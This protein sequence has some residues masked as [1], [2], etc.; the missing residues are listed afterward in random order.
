M[1]NTKN[2][3]LFESGSFPG[4]NSWGNYFAQNEKLPLPMLDRFHKLAIRKLT[5]REN[6][7]TG[8]QNAKP[9]IEQNACVDSGKSVSVSK[10]FQCVHRV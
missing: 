6:D 3:Q 8:E 10:R 7:T 2:E 1:Y 4:R 9:I 5:I